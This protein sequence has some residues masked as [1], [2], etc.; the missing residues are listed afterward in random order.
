[1]EHVAQVA[2]HDRP[3]AGRPEKAALL[4]LAFEIVEEGQNHLARRRRRTFERG[5]R[6]G[7]AV[8]GAEPFIAGE[9]HGLREIERGIGRVDGE[10]QDRV[11]EADFVIGQSRPLRSEQNPL[12]LAGF[13]AGQRLGH[14]FHRG[15]DAFALAAL[16]RRGRPQKMQIGDGCRDAVIKPGLAEQMLGAGGGG[17]GGLAP[18]PAQRPAFARIDEAQVGEAEIAHRP[19]AHADIH[20]ELRPHEND[21]R[22]AGNGGPRP[23][24]SGA[25]HWGSS[26]AVMAIIA[27][28][29]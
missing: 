5:E 13:D 14:R 22:A 3:L 25:G 12:V 1:M 18:G 24:C 4:E 17:I 23:V 9:Q 27:G 2:L 10:G 26:Q 20:G 6:Q 11:G 7:I 8:G 21:R 28:R 29:H 19:R 16:A 15:G